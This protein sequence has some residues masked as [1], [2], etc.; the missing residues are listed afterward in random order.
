MDLEKKTEEL[1]DSILNIV[2]DEK[3]AKDFNKKV[4][5]DCPDDDCDCQGYWEQNIWL[6][7]K[8]SQVLKERG[9]LID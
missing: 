8:Q 5:I 1:M 3:N 2:S 4:R 9:F 6:T 7:E